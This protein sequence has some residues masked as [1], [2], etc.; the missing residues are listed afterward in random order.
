MT[1]TK[2]ELIEDIQESET[3]INTLK[4]NNRFLLSQQKEFK[5]MAE[6]AGTK[7]AKWKHTCIKQ[8]DELKRLKSKIKYIKN[9]KR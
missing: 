1:K 5:S 8:E 3:T 4:Q 7:M 2:Q 6:I 9:E